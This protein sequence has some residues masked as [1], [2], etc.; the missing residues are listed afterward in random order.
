MTYI[1]NT[2]YITINKD[3]IFVGGKPATKYRGKEIFNIRY[4]KRQFSDIQKEY[5][6]VM[7]LH[8]L[9]SETSGKYA[10]PGSPSPIHGRYSWYRA[11]FNDGK[12]GAWVC[13]SVDYG[14][15]V[16]CAKLCAF[17][18][19]FH[20][21]NNHDYRQAVFGERTGKENVQSTQKQVAKPLTPISPVVVAINNEAQIKR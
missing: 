4:V 16:G 6:G 18:C 15:T 21:K 3:G 5:P 13:S 7:E 17:N 19:V 14:D 8:V 1:R 2:K 11:K 12:T 9:S 20:I 10:E